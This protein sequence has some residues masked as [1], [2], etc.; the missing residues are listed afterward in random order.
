MSHGIRIWGANGALQIDE[1]SFTLRVVHSEVIANQGWFQSGPYPGMGYRDWS[2]PG[3]HPG[4]A[5]ATVL[6]IGFYDENAT[7]FETEMLSNTV[8]V[9]NYNRSYGG[10]WRATAAQM[11]LLVVRFR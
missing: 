1:T 9:F 3:V 11:R 10:T 8:R 6:P 2:I 7:Q 5:I 4:N